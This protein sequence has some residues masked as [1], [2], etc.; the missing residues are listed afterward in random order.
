MPKWPHGWRKWPN[1]MLTH[2]TDPQN[3]LMKGIK[4]HSVPGALQGR[5]SKKKICATFNQNIIR[6]Q[7]ITVMSKLQ[8]LCGW[9]L[10][11]GPTLYYWACDYLSMLVLKLNHV[12]KSSSGSYLTDTYAIVT[13]GS[14][15]L[16][17]KPHCHW[18]EGLLYTISGF[19]SV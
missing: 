19:L 6:C 18:T 17:W 15:S 2:A 14:A 3:F 8:W 5:I 1:H 11:M 16:F 13:N 4:I 9:I 12:S 10:G 7:I